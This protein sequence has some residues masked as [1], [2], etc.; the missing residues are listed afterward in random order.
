[1]N[2]RC[3]DRDI[4]EDYG[5]RRDVAED[6]PAD[7]RSVLEQI[8]Q[9]PEGERPPASTNARPRRNPAAV[10]LRLRSSVAA[11]SVM[12]RRE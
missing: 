11:G 10:N 6:L 8:A 7:L 2:T 1:M 4:E 5:R 3:S 9:P 12:S